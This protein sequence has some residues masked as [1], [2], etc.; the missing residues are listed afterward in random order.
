MIVEKHKLLREKF[1]KMKSTGIF[2]LLLISSSICTAFQT[3]NDS[4]LIEI[5]PEKSSDIDA[6]KTLTENDNKSEL[7]SIKS[8]HEHDE[9]T[10]STTQKFFEYHEDHSI[11]FLNE[12]GMTEGALENE[13]DYIFEEESASEEPLDYDVELSDELNYDE[14]IDN[15]DKNTLESI[16]QE[17]KVIYDREQYRQ[18]ANCN[19]SCK[20]LTSSTTTSDANFFKIS[21]ALLVFVLAIILSS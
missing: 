2:L 4:I 6:N 20:K 16:E 18:V 19:T 3:D 14:S 11:D 17:S 8:S 1:N 21:H 5:L 13:T 15:S 9:V 12:T 10:E 7:T